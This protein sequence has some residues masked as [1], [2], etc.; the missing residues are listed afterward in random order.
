[1]P[2]KV[3]SAASE[4]FVLPEWSFLMIP[5]YARFTM[6]ALIV[7]LTVTALPAQQP[8]AQGFEIQPPP[9]Q[10]TMGADEQLRTLMR[11]PVHEAFA[12]PFILNPEPGLQVPQLPPPDVREV[13]PDIRPEGSG[14]VQWIPGYWGWE[15][16]K[17][18]I[19]ISGIWRDA[20]PQMR[21]MPGYWSRM[22]DA[23]RWVR[24]FWLREDAEDIDY[25][26]QPPVSKENGPMGDAP[27]ENHFWVPGVWVLQEGQFF[28]RDG[29]W[30]DVHPEYMWTPAQ[31]YWSPR[32][33][34]FVDGYWDYP[35]D[36]R[37][38]LFAPILPPANP[39]VV[40]SPSVVVDAPAVMCHLFVRPTY[41]HYYFG[42]YY[43]PRFVD[44][45]FRPWIS[46][47]FYDPIRVFYRQCR[48][49]V[50]Q[51]IVH[52]HDF[53]VRNPTWRPPH[54]YR[55]F[56]RYAAGIN[57]RDGQGIHIAINFRDQVSRSRGVGFANVTRDFHERHGAAKDFYRDIVAKRSHSEHD[58][59]KSFKGKFHLSDKIAPDR[60]PRE[61][62]EKKDE[63]KSIVI[64]SDGKRRLP[65]PPQHVTKG[66]RLDPKVNPNL[67][68]P[69]TIN[70]PRY[71]QP[72]R[73]LTPR[74][75]G[76]P[77]KDDEPKKFGP[78]KK[79][80]PPM[81]DDQPKKPG[82]PKS[83][84][85]GG[86][87]RID[88]PPKKDTTPMQPK[89][90]PAPQ[91]K[92]D[93][94]PS[95]Q[96]RTGSPPPKNDNAPPMQPRTGSPPPQKDNTP[97]M[98]PRVNPMPQPKQEGQPKKSF[99]PPMQPKVNPMPQPKTNVQ[100]RPNVVQP[101]QFNPPPRN[102]SA[103]K[104]SFSQPKSFSAPRVSPP[105]SFSQPKQSRPAE[106]QRPSSGGRPPRRSSLDRVDSTDYAAA[107]NSCNTGAVWTRDLRLVAAT[108]EKT[109]I[110]SV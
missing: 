88:G 62:I 93:Y 48:P 90:D 40:Y 1:M 50:Y 42:D 63:P 60:S 24:G 71:V 36:R 61:R 35:P 102:E 105:N 15:D 51:T 59:D 108:S 84:G 16:G 76:P 7:G 75:D 21:W 10:P 5:R 19:W 29:F 77:R 14:E 8:F 30:A 78:P 3:T 41:C 33:Y 89:V 38:T 47:G 72:K 23:V 91:L 106:K 66:P 74:N 13:P 39:Q 54:N 9:P 80:G 85:P 58:H 56:R 81:K 32:G 55:D 101:R 82:T 64:K 57:D 100:S 22:G 25:L 92:K 11:G 99:A 12:Q 49:T 43:E 83:D 18:F 98:Q 87:P 28:W 97:P 2:S 79:E 37:G 107:A 45:G 68:G 46:F 52:R 69:G 44:F 26:P 6:S 70:D 103:P 86:T 110:S 4:V 73:D 34:V 53:F 20:P 95:T 96:P 104:K 17:G 27:G 109:S 67:A 94:T 31:Y 65:P